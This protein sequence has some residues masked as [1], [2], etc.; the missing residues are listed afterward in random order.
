MA[1]PPQSTKTSLQQRLSG[2]A[3]QRWPQVAAIEVRFRAQYA[4]VTAELADG[5]T[6]PLMRLR[7][8]ESA[9]MWGFAVYLASRG[10]YQDSVLANGHTAGT[11]E[12]ALDT[13]CGQYLGD[14]TAW[15]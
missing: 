4:D 12:D 7:Y 1:T 15:I 10:G 5:S 6:Q 9:S 13:A 11:P 3:R 8:A 14:P 2:R